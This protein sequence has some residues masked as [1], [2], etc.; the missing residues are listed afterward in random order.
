MAAQAID[1][2]RKLILALHEAGALLLLGSD[3][4]QIFNVPG[5]SLHHE[6]QFM[7]AAGLTPYAALRSGTT[8]PADFFGINTG[9]VEIGRIADLVLLDA[10]P[11]EDISN[12]GRVHGVLVAGRWATAVELLDGL[13]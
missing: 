4:P 12:S 8:A 13:E 7:V 1:I 6:L 5:F 10:N 3:A 11:L 2:R 9:T